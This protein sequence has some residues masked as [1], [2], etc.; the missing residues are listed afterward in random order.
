[1]PSAPAAVPD[2]Q[3][4][5][6]V[7]F[8]GGKDSVLALHIVSAHIGHALLSHPTPATPPV[9]LLV[10]FRPP[11]SNCKAHPLPI[12]QA[13]A[14]SLGIAHVCLDVHGPLYQDSFLATAN[15]CAGCTQSTPSPT[16]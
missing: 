14:A 4:A 16:W 2:K 13:L 9:T 10:T 6:A 3:M 1:M 15:S 5:T 7:S 12:I 8:T 11:D